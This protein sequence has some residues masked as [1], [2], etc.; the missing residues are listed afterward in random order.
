MKSRRWKSDKRHQKKLENRKRLSQ[1]RINSLSEL[2][3]HYNFHFYCSLKGKT[4]ANP[5]WV[6]TGSIEAYSDMHQYKVAW[7]KERGTRRWWNMYEDHEGKTK[8]ELAP[9][10]SFHWHLWDPS[11]T[12]QCGG[13]TERQTE[14]TY[15]CPCNNSVRPLRPPMS[16]IMTLWSDA[17]ENSSLWTGSHHSAPTLPGGGGTKEYLWHAIFKQQGLVEDSFMVWPVG[18][19]CCMREELQGCQQYKSRPHL[20]LITTTHG[21]CTVKQ[22]WVL[23]S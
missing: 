21:R 17:P 5:A 23:C 12:G 16:H 22:Y 3:E 9:G 8:S 6:P 18:A 20:F 11:L 2:Q 15:W 13:V 19:T 7:Y 1:N 10:E 14:T 4:S